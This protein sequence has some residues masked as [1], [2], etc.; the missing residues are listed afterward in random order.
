MQSTWKI[1]LNSD[2]NLAT[3]VVFERVVSCETLSS[4]Y[5]NLLSWS[6]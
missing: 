4:V 1:L 3:L 5:R 2:I 6:P